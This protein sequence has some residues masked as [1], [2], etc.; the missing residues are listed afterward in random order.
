MRFPRFTLRIWVFFSAALVLYS[1]IQAA[2]FL[3]QFGSEPDRELI[4][5]YAMSQGVLVWSRAQEDEIRH[6]LGE[7]YFPDGLIQEIFVNLE[8]LEAQSA[9]GGSE[10][11]YSWSDELE[12]VDYVLEIRGGRTGL[13]TLSYLWGA[14]YQL[15]YILVDSLTSSLLAL[16]IML[17][18]AFIVARG[19][20]AP[21]LTLEDHAL[22]IAGR[23]LSVPIVL[24]RR[25]EIGDL[26]RS[27]ERM[28][29]Q[30]REKDDAQQRFFQSISHE[31]KTPVMVIRSH[32]QAIE[33]GIGDAEENLG[34]IDG[35]ALK[36]GE[37]VAKLVSLSK[38]GYLASHGE[39]E[40]L[41]LVFLIRET[42]RRLLPA[43]DAS[44]AHPRGEVIPGK[45]I[46]WEIRGEA[47]ELVLNRDLF[48]ILLENLLDNQIRYARS[49]IFV[50]LMREGD[51]LEIG[52]GNDGPPFREGEE[53]KVF[54]LFYK[55]ERGCSGLGLTIARD[56]C[57]SWGGTVRAENSSRGPRFLISLPIAEC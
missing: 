31:M 16:L 34:I 44:I 15:K 35:E 2:V 18:P 3:Y 25:D 28:R 26:G 11:S 27:L 23:D 19:I 14:S 42:G 48:V 36:L 13:A 24:K 41:N 20:A 54:K 30:L 51:T 37:R 52:I 32:V 55:G 43:A 12:R 46:H 8:D 7:L 17:I 22:R 29:L 21:L 47:P 5:E 39:K 6:Q 38:I 33:D 57:V 49:L 53:E 56:I 9:S 40:A 45:E 4:R 10:R 1:L 50:D